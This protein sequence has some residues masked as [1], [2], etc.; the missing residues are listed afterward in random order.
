[1]KTDQEL[2]HLFATHIAGFVDVFFNEP[3]GRLMAPERSGGPCFETVPDFCASADAVLP[4]LMDHYVGFTFMPCFRHD[5]DRP[6]G[7]WL[8]CLGGDGNA[9]TA[10]TFAKAAVLALLRAHNIE[11]E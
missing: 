10:P 4:W 3:S 9:A 6:T 8:L 7:E 11:T 2:C 5:N 1:M